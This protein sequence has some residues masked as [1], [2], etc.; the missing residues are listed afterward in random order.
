MFF[1]LDSRLPIIGMDYSYSDERCKKVS[2]YF[3]SMNSMIV[4]PSFL[5]LLAMMNGLFDKESILNYAE[6][7]LSYRKAYVNNILDEMVSWDVAH[8]ES[9]VNLW[10]SSFDK[11]YSTEFF[12]R[13]DLRFL[14]VTPALIDL[15]LLLCKYNFNS[16]SFSDDDVTIKRENV[17]S[18]VL[19][20]ESDVGRTLSS[21]IAMRRNGNRGSHIVE[22]APIK[23]ACETIFLCDS[24]TENY[25]DYCDILLDANDYRNN[26][27]FCRRLAFK[28]S[29]CGKQ[30]DF[31]FVEFEHM[32]RMESDVVF[33]VIDGFYE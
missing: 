10:G 25:Y 6:K 23:E 11:E 13:F 18:S 20:Q 4:D 26:P 29:S 7:A 9:R 2:V 24:F 16:I 3:K 28:A 27:N 12:S 32:L 22:H 21:L 19:L 33:G 5:E 17:E 8:E 30:I 14:S 15:S 31:Q 1:S